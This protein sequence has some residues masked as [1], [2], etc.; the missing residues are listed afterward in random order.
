MADP[1]EPQREGGNYLAPPHA[2]AAKS[3]EV[4]RGPGL[5]LAGWLAASLAAGPL[6]GGVQA[7]AQPAHQVLPQPLADL[8]GPQ[9]MRGINL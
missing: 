8:R 3:V 9:V 6:R 4:G 7:L 2:A 1:A 5:H